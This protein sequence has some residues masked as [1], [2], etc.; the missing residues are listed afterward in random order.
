LH[1]F[2]GHP[3][4]WVQGTLMTGSDQRSGAARRSVDRG[5]KLLRRGRAD[6]PFSNL[7]FELE[8]VNPSILNSYHAVDLD[9]Q[10]AQPLF[11]EPRPA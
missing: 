5:A 6:L 1:F 4:P 11:A 2:I 3:D 10:L 9:S 8:M 7:R